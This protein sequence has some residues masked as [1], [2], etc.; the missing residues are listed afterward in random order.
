M[1]RRGSTIFSEIATLIGMAR[2]IRA[3]RPDI[4][5]LVTSKPIIY[6]GVLARMLGIPAVSSISGLGH[7]FIGKGL[8]LALMRVLVVVGYRLSL[9]RR[10]SIAI[11]QNNSDLGLFR[12]LGIV[13]EG[14][15][16]LIPGSGVDLSAIRPAPLPAGPTVVALPARLLRDKGVVEFVEASRILRSEG[17]D[18]AFR[19]IGDLDPGNPTS[20]TPQELARWE[21]EGVVEVYPYTRDV[22]AALAC[23]HIVALPS[24][25]EGFPKTLIDAAAAGRACA[26]TD[27]PGCRDAVIDGQTGV[28]FPARDSKAMAEAL[29]PL[30]ASR[31]RQAAMG[32]AARAHAEAHFAIGDVVN[33]NLA[34]YR[35]LMAMAVE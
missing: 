4:I 34:I 28:L 12:K 31:R 20:V 33:R 8:K 17:A 21:A 25:R 1:R 18:C 23:C 6:G 5:H 26:T 29:R 11:F 22:G 13:R 2:A 3:F 15:F 35:Q 30:I 7:V 10:R 27:V 24:Y 32:A 19:L 14:G 9:S 16:C